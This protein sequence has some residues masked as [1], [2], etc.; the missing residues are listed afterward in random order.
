MHLPNAK[1]IA[2]GKVFVSGWGQ[3]SVLQWE[4][5]LHLKIASRFLRLPPQ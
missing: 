4:G 3:V 5:G 1:I 2:D